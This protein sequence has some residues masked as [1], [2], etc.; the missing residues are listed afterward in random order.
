MSKYL[1][2]NFTVYIEPTTGTPAWNFSDLGQFMSII[3]QVV[4]IVA[5]LGAFVFLILGGIQ[6]L[7]SGGEKV[8]VEAARNRITYAIMG[9]V[10]IVGTYALTRVIETVFGISIVS[11]ITWPGP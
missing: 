4:I 5:G 3:L 9:L 10:I 7:T 8:Q 2:A 6:F 1:A 11:G